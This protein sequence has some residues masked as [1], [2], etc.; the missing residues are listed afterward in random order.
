MCFPNIQGAAGPTGATGATG[1]TEPTGPT[2]TVEPNPF[3]VYVQAGAV[4]RLGRHRGFV[5]DGAVF[6]FSG[7]SWGSPENAAD[8][9]LLVGTLTGLPY[10]PL[11]DLSVN[12]SDALIDDQR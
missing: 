1:P 9:A 12:N 6:V 8:I 4:N 10:D 5:V 11:S 7:N 3:D 2:G